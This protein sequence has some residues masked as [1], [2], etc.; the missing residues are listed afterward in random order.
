MPSHDHPRLRIRDLFIII[1]VCAMLLAAAGQYRNGIWLVLVPGSFYLPFLL[2]CT[3]VTRKWVLIVAVVVLHTGVILMWPLAMLLAHGA[4]DE[5]P[6]LATIV[7]IDLPLLPLYLGLDLHP[8][9]AL[10]VSVVF[11]GL[12]YGVVAAALFRLR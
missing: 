9:I 5:I 1:T 8:Y 6:L 2:L 3:L 7:I 10:P 4:V 12:F 11:G